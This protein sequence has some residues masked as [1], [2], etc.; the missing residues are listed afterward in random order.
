MALNVLFVVHTDAAAAADV[1]MMACVW[2]E[3]DGWVCEDRADVS[4]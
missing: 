4:R 2:A 1:M 3:R